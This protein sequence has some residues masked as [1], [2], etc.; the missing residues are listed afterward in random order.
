MRGQGARERGR[1]SERRGKKEK[2]RGEERWE[3]YRI[4]GGSV[5]YARR[6]F[7]GL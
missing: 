2:S 5:W 3:V 7:Q 1:Y 6:V 4:G